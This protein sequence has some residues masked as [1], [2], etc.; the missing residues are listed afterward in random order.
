MAKIL[1]IDDEIQVR[2][3]IRKILEA[4][5]HEVFEAA[6]GEIGLK[7]YQENPVD[8]IITD[9]VMP[10]KEGIEII[11][12]LKRECPDVKIIAI[13][14]GSGN[15]GSENYLCL[16]KELGAAKTISKPFVSEELLKIV[17]E[18]L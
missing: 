9:I 11:I 14:G 13:S 16:A 6:N 2:T 7:M 17:R 15:F 18:V 1:V 3:Y 10:E 8:L 5:D 12:E 4:E